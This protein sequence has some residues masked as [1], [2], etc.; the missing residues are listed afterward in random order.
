MKKKLAVLSFITCLVFSLAITQE[1]ISQE[2]DSS[3]E[4]DK[5]E[6]ERSLKVL[7][8]DFRTIGELGE[9]SGSA[10]AQALSELLRE[11]P[12]LRGKYSMLDRERVR[13]ELEGLNTSNNAQVV[14]TG[15]VIS[16]D[17]ILIGK[18]ERAGGLRTA[19]ITA[20]LI[21]TRTG[22]DM[23]KGAQVLKFAEVKEVDIFDPLGMQDAIRKIGAE[24]TSGEIPRI[25]ISTSRF[26]LITINRIDRDELPLIKLTVSVTDRA[27]NPIEVPKEVF[28]VQEE[29][30]EV[31]ID[32]K[33]AK[34]LKLTRPF[35]LVLVMDKSGSMRGEAFKQAQAAAISFIDRLSEQ[36]RVLV[37]AFG[38]DIVPLGLL[39][40]KSQELVDNI[41]ALKAEGGTALYAALYDSLS[42]IS[43]SPGEKAVILLTDGK[44][45]VRNSSQEIKKHTLEGGLELARDTGIPVYTV[46]FGKGA[47]VEVLGRIAH[48][49]HSLYQKAETPED[50]LQVYLRLNNLLENQYII[51]YTTK[52]LGGEVN[53]A[54][55]DKG[56]S[57][58]YQ[59]SFEEKQKVI[60]QRQTKLANKEEELAE[61]EK[62]LQAKNRELDD[63]VKELAQREEDLKRNEAGLNEQRSALEDKERVLLEQEKTLNS[64]GNQLMRIL[65]ERINSLSSQG[66]STD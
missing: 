15:R 49:T 54:A 29:G 44:N 51:S 52:S 23:G 14:E 31:E 55:G 3:G 9:I 20:Q 30:I 5:K 26:D 47:D 41:N 12:E 43:A 6:I 2:A 19:T 11:D 60:E 53:V 21:D 28:Q 33:H 65:Q 56:D 46:G 35:S 24:I 64:Q 57:R 16:A 32:V 36:D 63:R 45:D 18:I 8:A 58:V 66:Y 7:V 1:A 39:A 48:E 27:G 22:V 25:N 38:N 50:I 13:S 4:G 34:E 61:R 59:T 17:G 62:E 40:R 42:R 10:I 37:L